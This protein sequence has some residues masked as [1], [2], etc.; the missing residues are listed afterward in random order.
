MTE[1]AFLSR[2]RVLQLHLISLQQHG[3]MDGLR[4]SGLLDSALMQPEA[5]FYYR[6]GDMAA[7]AAA[8]AFHLAQN[9][10][11]IDGNKRTAITSALAFLELNGISATAI[12]DAELYDH[13]RHRRE[14]ARQGRVG[15]NLPETP[16]DMTRGNS[17][18]R[19][20]RKERGGE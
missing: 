5:A 13:D 2:E 17:I 6:Q 15:G 19:G 12:T 8:Y 14:A 4:E 9:Q 1:P 7:V 3:G 11:F 16:A 20:E 10:P 18:K